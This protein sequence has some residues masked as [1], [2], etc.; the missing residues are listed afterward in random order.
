M[1]L[2]VDIFKLKFYVRKKGTVPF[3][4]ILA[5]FKL[6]TPNKFFRYEAYYKSHY[7]CLKNRL[8]TDFVF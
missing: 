8:Q 5:Y 3:V 7:D 1:S 6:C 2:F 4:T